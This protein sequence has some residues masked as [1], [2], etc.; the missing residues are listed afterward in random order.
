[1]KKKHCAIEQCRSY[2]CTHK[3]LQHAQQYNYKEGKEQSEY[4]NNK[5][6]MDVV[7]NHEPDHRLQT[8]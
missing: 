8:I 4:S 7:H 2:Q 3:M 5:A 1:M 6:C